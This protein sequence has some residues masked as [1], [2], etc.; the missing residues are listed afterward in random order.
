MSRQV[1]AQTEAD[2]GRSFNTGYS[3][4]LP[5]HISSLDPTPAGSAEDKSW[6]MFPG[7]RLI[8]SI[9]KYT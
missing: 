1:L 7:R 6:S 5:P 8:A 9:F 4:R 3:S 2:E